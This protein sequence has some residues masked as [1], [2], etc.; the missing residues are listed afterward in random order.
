MEEI[1]GLIFQESHAFRLLNYTSRCYLATKSQ[2]GGIKL[3]LSYK[4][5]DSNQADGILFS[6]GKDLIDVVN[7]MY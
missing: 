3:E 1:T 7:V 6:L 4:R 5:K 2:V